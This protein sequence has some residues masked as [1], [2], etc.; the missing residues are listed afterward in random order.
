MQS[1]LP[2]NNRAAFH[3]LR[4]DQWESYFELAGFTDLG[5]M[6][7]LLLLDIYLYTDDQMKLN[8]YLATILLGWQVLML[9]LPTIFFV[10][11]YLT[12]EKVVTSLGKKYE[13]I[14]NYRI[15]YQVKYYGGIAYMVSMIV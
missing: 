10:I 6:I 9:W 15:S 12:P 7:L 11:A 8:K 4:A 14:R 13:S 5:A 1:I 2:S 3:K